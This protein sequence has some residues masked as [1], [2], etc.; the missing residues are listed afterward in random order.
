MGR[1]L[2]PS[3]SSCAYPMWPQGLSGPSGGATNL[4]PSRAAGRIA[5]RPCRCD[6]AF[7]QHVLAE[8]HSTYER[9]PRCPMLDALAGAMGLRPKRLAVDAL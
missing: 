2:L 7:T 5:K 3:R 9:W 8:P 6:R 4:P 1:G